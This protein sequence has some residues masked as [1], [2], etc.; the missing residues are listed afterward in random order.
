VDTL[1]GIIRVN[2]LAVA[3]HAVLRD[4]PR[5]YLVVSESD[6]DAARLRTDIEDLRRSGELA[7]IIERMNLD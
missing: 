5:A 7:K 2:G 1:K 6:E 4:E 3:D